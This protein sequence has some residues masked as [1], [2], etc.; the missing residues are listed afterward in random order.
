MLV[1][2]LGRDLDFDI[3]R[4][5]PDVELEWAMVRSVA[6]QAKRN[7]TSQNVFILTIKSFNGN[8]PGELG[9]RGTE[10]M[11]KVSKEARMKIILY[12]FTI[13]TK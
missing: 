13:G 11:E 4:P 3:I 2:L 5:L 1:E 7:V 12:Y 10:P 9:G 6:A 8:T